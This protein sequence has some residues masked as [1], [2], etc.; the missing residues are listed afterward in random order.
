MN[1]NTRRDFL[2]ISGLGSVAIIGEYSL[3]PFLASG[4][5]N[6]ASSSAQ[7][8]QY[9]I[10]SVVVKT[11]N[12][13]VSFAYTPA[14][15]A[16]ISGVMPNPANPPLSPNGGVALTWD[17]LEQV[18][19]YESLGYGLWQFG[20]P[21]EVVARTDIMANPTD[22]LTKVNTNQITQKTRLLNFAAMTD[23]HITDKEAPN[24][25]ITLQQVN[26]G[27]D[28]QNTSIYSPIMPYTTQVLDAAI[29][30]INAL[31]KKDSFDFF[32]SLGDTCNSTMY[33]EL[34]WY[35]DIIDGKVITP[36]SG[37][38]LGANSIDYQKP[39]Q[40][41]G[42]DK[43]LPWYQAIGNHDQFY[44]GSFPVYADA[45]VNLS[46]SYITSAVWSIPKEV[47][48][49]NPSTFPAMF[50]NQ[51]LINQSLAQ[52][53]GGVINGRTL[54][55][56]IIDSGAVGNYSTV[57]QVAPDA[58]RR[59]LLKSE[60]I[61]EFFNS[62]TS[63][64]GHGFG[65]VDPSMPVGFACYSFVPK[66]NIPLKIIVLDD[67]QNTDDG[68]V[69]IHGHGFLDATRWAWLQ[70][71]LANGQAA[72]QLMIIAAHIPIG[73]S[74]ISSETEWW[75]GGNKNNPSVLGDWS[76]TTQNAVDITGL[77]NTLWN[78]P[79]LLMW[80]AGHRHVNAVKAFVSPDPTNAPEKGFWQVETSSV[81]DFPQQFRTFE[82]YLNSDYTVC[83][84]AINVD[85]AVGEGTPA[86]ISRKCAITAQQIVQ[87]NLTGNCKN[88]AV[89]P[90]T[91][92]ALP[93][94]DPS[95]PQN[96]ELDPSIQYIDLSPSVPFN[97]SYNARLFKQLSSDM[98]AELRRLKL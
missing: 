86:A 30:T 38:N 83:V 95:R 54:L 55:G 20:A 62:T 13:M 72:N 78:T 71:E 39:F 41:A 87:N 76:T 11:T 80:I 24:Q 61:G 43:T 92:I 52:Y 2:K 31:H 21:L 19:S 4:C 57:P 58:N 51:N 74:N 59:S 89:Q 70:K 98:K 85:V 69:D 60:W 12:R 45:S 9:P 36:S 14:S 65:L 3:I 64:N 42:L 33:N 93:T 94:M 8:T 63:P 90:D 40:A 56:T 81:R 25:I 46:N 50:N 29:Q 5:G 37:A 67:N 53:Y 66:S 35:I 7:I 97:A 1:H 10:D 26:A 6:S 75:L 48:T 91:T 49:P 77:V 16:P 17:K 22:Y 73:V 32:I 23:I 82:I 68:S 47:L 79:N 88:Y 44:L 15:T 27:F 84:D 96:G 34:R 18:A 28:G